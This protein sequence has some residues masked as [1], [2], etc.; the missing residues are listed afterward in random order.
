MLQQSS[1]NKIRLICRII[2]SVQTVVVGI[3]LI[4]SCLAIYRS[5]EAPFKPEAIAAQFKKIAIPVYCYFFCLCFSTVVAVV[6]PMEEVRPRAKT[7][8]A[9]KLKK[10]YAKLGYGLSNA[11]AE[12]KKACAKERGKRMLYR[13][14]C[15]VICLV[16]AL[17]LIVYLCDLSHFTPK[18]NESVIAASYMALPFV[19][20]GGAACFVTDWLMCVS[21]QREL[22]LLEAIPTQTNRTG[23]DVLTEGRSKQTA[24]TW[25]NVVRAVLLVLAATMIFLG[26]SNGGMRDVLGKAIK[27]CTECIGLG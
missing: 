12:Q 25:M 23:N 8:V 19:I 6:M 4:L 15:T 7:D 11:S 13:V 18:L 17:P 27:I 14:A 9:A 3:C 2:L 20:L 21:R 24:Q 5:G 22:K 16:A 26:I 1:Q 10:Q